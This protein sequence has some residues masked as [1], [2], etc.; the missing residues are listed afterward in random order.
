MTSVVWKPLWLLWG[1]ANGSEVAGELVDSTLS[2][3]AQ[4]AG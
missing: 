2:R 3:T 4:D 1:L